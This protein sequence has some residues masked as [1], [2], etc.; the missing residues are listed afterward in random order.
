MLS[1]YINTPDCYQD[2]PRQMRTGGLMRPKRWSILAEVRDRLQAAWWVL[3][4]RGECI[5]YADCEHLIYRDA[6]KEYD[7]AKPVPMSD[8]EIEQAARVATGKEPLHHEKRERPNTA[9][10]LD[11]GDSWMGAVS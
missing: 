3:I 9:Q 5:V 11:R 4:G 1:P 2:K 6:Q 8:E 7:R 10:Y